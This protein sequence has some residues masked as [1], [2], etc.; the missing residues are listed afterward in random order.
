MPMETCPLKR[1]EM[2][3]TDQSSVSNPVGGEHDR[4]IADP[5]VPL[6][7]PVDRLPRLYLVAHPALGIRKIGKTVADRLDL[8]RQRG[9]ILIDEKSFTDR[10]AL[11]AAERL[12]LERLD[13]LGARATVRM[14][15]LF[16]NLDSNG[17]H[18][19]FDPDLFSG[20]IIDLLG[21]A[22]G[23]AARATEPV[24]PPWIADARSHAALKAHEHPGRDQAA[25]ARKA[26]RTKMSRLLKP[27]IK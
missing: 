5:A 27:K 8:W 2:G 17:R 19:M 3:I 22:V 16:P 26:A 18:E 14:G 9:W 4:A 7:W 12:A 15:A 21:D 1:E 10:A 13:R 25:A 23:Q 24:V 11:A 20:G 6:P